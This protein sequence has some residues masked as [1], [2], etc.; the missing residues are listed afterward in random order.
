MLKE[1]LAPASVHEFVRG[2]FGRTPHARPGTA[3]RAVRWFDW[4]V[5]GR[6][7]AQRPPDMLVASRG[8]LVEVPAPRSL[9]DVRQLM[10]AGL[11]LVIRKSEQHDP[12]LAQ[13]ARAFAR[14]LPGEI[15]VQLY[16]TPAGTQA[17]GWHYDFEDV[18][19]AQ[20]VG[21]KDYHFRDNT[22]A[23]DTPIGEQPDFSCIRRETSP[24]LGSQLIPGD[25]LYIPR[26]WWHLVHSVEDSMSISIGVLPA[27]LPP[28]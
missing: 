17:F 3:G 11:G 14:D 2:Y 5:L 15:H 12:Q 25:W 19:I 21:M 8:H 16:V 22:V 26:R 6:V 28:R 27:E 4:S 7:L 24:L 9:S 23:R 18:F 10:A 13:L 1:W 20:T